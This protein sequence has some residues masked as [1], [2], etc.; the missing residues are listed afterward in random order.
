MTELEQLIEEI[1]SRVITTQQQVHALDERLET[2]LLLE[3]MN[4]A[5]Q[6]SQDFDTYCNCDLTSCIQQ[7]IDDLKK[8]NARLDNIRSCMEF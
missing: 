4:R 6:L 2:V 8:I 7:V 1:S 5:A 3:A